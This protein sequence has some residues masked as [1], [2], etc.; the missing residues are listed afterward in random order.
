MYKKIL[1]YLLFILPIQF[2]YILVAQVNLQPILTYPTCPGSTILIPFT[3]N[4]VV[5]HCCSCGNSVCC[6]DVYPFPNNYVARIR[7]K[8]SGAIFTDLFISQTYSSP[9]GGIKAIL[10]TSPALPSG[11]Y[12]IVVVAVAGG[13]SCG[14]QDVFSN[15][16]EVQI[17]VPN[18]VSISASGNTNFCADAPVKLTAV[19]G[20]VIFWKWLRNGLPILINASGIDYYPTESGD[21]S[22]EITNNFGC[23]STSNVIPVTVRKAPIPSFNTLNDDICKDLPITFNNTTTATLNPPTPTGTIN[24]IWDFGNGQTSTLANPVYTY[25]TAGTYTVTLRANIAGFCDRTTSQVITVRPRPN[26]SI[27]ILG[28]PTICLPDPTRLQA[29]AAPLNTTYTY[30]WFFNNILITGATQQNYIPTATGSYIVRVTDFVSGCD[31]LSL[32]VNIVVSAKPKS[33]ISASATRVCENTPINF[34]A[35]T[36]IPISPTPPISYLWSFGDGT[37][38]T[39]TVQNPS[40]TYPF[41]GFYEVQLV[42]STGFCTDIT[43]IVIR[44]DAKPIASFSASEVCFGSLTTFTNTS[45]NAISQVWNFGNSTTSTSLNPSLIYPVAGDYTVTLTVRSIDNCSDTFTQLV[46]VRPVPNVQF[47]NSLNLCSNKPITFTNTTTDIGE[48]YTC[49]W[50]FGN[51]IISNLCNATTSYPTVGFFTVTL[52]ITYTGAASTCSKIITKQIYINENPLADFLA[53]LAVCV[54]EP[55][56]FTNTSGNASG[57][58]SNFNYLWTITNTNGTG[59]AITYNTKNISHTFAT[60]GIYDVKM[61]IIN[62]VSGCNEQFIRQITINPKPQ[63]AFVTPKMLCIPNQVLFI[64]NATISNGGIQFYFFDFGDGSPI[65]TT[66]NPSTIYIYA[67]AGNYNVKIWSK[68]FVGCTS[69]IFS[70]LVNVSPILVS[71]FTNTPPCRSTEIS[72]QDTSIGVSLITGWA[73]DFG[74]G[75]A[76]NI[77]NPIHTYTQTGTYNVSLTTTDVNNCTNTK[78]KTITVNSPPIASFS[79]SRESFCLKSFT[80]RDTLKLSNQSTGTNSGWTFQWI[81]PNVLGILGTLNQPNTFII[82]SNNIP[83]GIYDL[84][85]V[86][87]NNFGCK[88]T[89]TAKFEIF[90]TFNLGID[91]ISLPS[92][93]NDRLTINTTGE[94]Q[95][96]IF[97]VEYQGTTR[98]LSSLPGSPT[99][100]ADI[101]PRP[102]ENDVTYKISITAQRGGCEQT[103]TKEIIIRAIPVIKFETYQ[104]PGSREITFYD[105]STNV[106]SDSTIWR[107]EEHQGCNDAYI[108]KAK[109][110]QGNIITDTLYS[111]TSNKNGVPLGK[112]H[113]I[114]LTV[115]DKYGIDNETPNG[116][117][118]PCKLTA[119]FFIDVLYF[120]RAKMPNGFSDNPVMPSE[121]KVFFPKLL[122]ER[123]K[124]YKIIV[125]DKW[126]KVV[127]EKQKTIE[128]NKPYSVDASQFEELKW[129]GKFQN[130]STDVPPDTYNYVIYIEYTDCD[131]FNASGMV[132]FIR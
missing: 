125:F 106:I 5:R 132:T 87:T 73:W 53:P 121:N 129:D 86:A 29:P 93:K 80:G 60:Q 78:T 91:V 113:K 62:M 35:T 126:N 68:S 10:P 50:D 116:T 83:Y 25:N 66:S 3:T 54:D 72:F 44:V 77:Q 11:V 115:T 34:N 28:N 22:V 6:Y 108:H 41:A 92:C 69:D 97:K 96:R 111:P 123:V 47:T 24:Y 59:T 64:N 107:I 114:T 122:L 30:R 48:P 56:S 118:K 37:G 100:A 51:G 94:A 131:T 27:N 102:T 85:M 8:G 104:A 103:F 16:Q 110:K 13:N 127:F 61:Q 42:T 32:P 128:H 2:F 79:L 40:Y 88:D 109:D 9:D 19:S 98:T 82:L 57:S 4:L 15:V 20:S 36:T 43:K 63:N 31:S 84:K 17:N 38:N 76:S 45:T 26:S 101:V 117:G 74:D 71:N 1:I 21:Y 105:K 119:T 99:Q 124:M 23:K 33:I 67:N 65:R 120:D 14:K 55:A 130:T 58:T 39:S 89:V 7:L 70:T 12:E 81:L 18:T 49:E 75:N 95:S 90:D 46:K 112:K 52:K